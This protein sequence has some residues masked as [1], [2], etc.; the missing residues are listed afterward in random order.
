MIGKNAALVREL[1][2]GL[3][4]TDRLMVALRYTEELDIQE[5]ASLTDLDPSEVEF[6]LDSVRIKVARVHAAQVVAEG[7]RRS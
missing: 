2:S 4:R 7:A 5:I 3:D 6:R 1:A